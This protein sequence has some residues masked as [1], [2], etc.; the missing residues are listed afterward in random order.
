MS[1]L[2]RTAEARP[3]RG[4]GLRAAPVAP[5]GT[6]QVEAALYGLGWRGAAHVVSS[7]GGRQPSWSERS[8]CRWK[9][10][11]IASSARCARGGR[12]RELRRGA[13]AGRRPVRAGGPPGDPAYHVPRVALACRAPHSRRAHPPSSVGRRL[14]ALTGLSASAGSPAASKF[15]RVSCSAASA[16]QSRWRSA[17]GRWWRRW[18]WRGQWRS[19]WGGWWG[20]G[21]GWWW[22]WRR[23]SWWR[24]WGW[25]VAVAGQR[26]PLRGERP[27]VP[28]QRVERGGDA[29]QRGRLLACIGAE[30][31]RQSAGDSWEDGRRSRSGGPCTRYSK[32]KGARCA[33]IGWSSTTPLHAISPTPTIASSLASARGSNPRPP[34]PPPP[35]VPPSGAASKSPASGRATSRQK[36]AWSSAVRPPGV[37]RGGEGVGSALVLVRR[38]QGLRSGGAL[39]RTAGKAASRPVMGRPCTPPR[40]SEATVAGGGSPR[41]GRR[42]LVDAVLLVA[43]GIEEGDVGR[44]VEHPGRARCLELRAA[45]GRG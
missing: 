39:Q 3:S 13:R 43:L 26:L 36:S 31:G 14:I 19:W 6:V 41:G 34:P 42:T 8:S 2:Q 17:W 20:W 10:R 4:G 29:A 15:S 35:A 27:V 45:Q 1:G 7:E 30:A 5:W 40:G 24:W 18:R 33:A 25:A 11:R 37:E 28:A 23:R 21:W 44:A 22:R 12:S 38:L 32:T 9:P 16:P